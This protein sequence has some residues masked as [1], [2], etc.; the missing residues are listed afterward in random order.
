M[1]KANLKFTQSGMTGGDCTAPYN[2]SFS[3]G[4]T[5]RELISDILERGE[6]GYIDI[7]APCFY[8]CEYKG[9]NVIDSPFPEEI[10]DKE[11]KRVVA[12]GG[13]SRMDYSV[14]LI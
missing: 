10:L 11:V 8:R 12:S 1:G 6:W 13:Y 7:E 4:C 5:L 9:R 3:P 2:V 14:Y